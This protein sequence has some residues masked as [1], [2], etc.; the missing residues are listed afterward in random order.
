MLNK[1]VD[2]RGR[3]YKLDRAAALA[4]PTAPLRPI[5]PVLVSI[6]RQAA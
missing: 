4:V 3:E 2:W 1:R 5:R 6:P